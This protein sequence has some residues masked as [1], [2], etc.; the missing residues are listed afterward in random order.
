MTAAAA[1]TAFPMV[2]VLRRGCAILSAE[3]TS[4]IAYSNS[5]SFLLL[6]CFLFCFV[7][8]LFYWGGGVEVGA[9]EGDVSVCLGFT[10]IRL[11]Q[12]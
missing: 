3:I 8:V 7:L 9:G 12:V 5:V 11:N 4:T 6:F 1:V 10:R 2:K